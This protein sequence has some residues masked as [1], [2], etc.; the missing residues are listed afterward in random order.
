M[1]QA[2]PSPDAEVP[3]DL[4]N[5]SRDSWRA[6]RRNGGSECRPWRH[7]GSPA[8]GASVASI[9]AAR[10]ASATDRPVAVMRVEQVPVTPLASLRRQ[11]VLLA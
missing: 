1:P 5:T 2:M 3:S 9:D 4:C 7:L 10:R 6:A 8:P 11:S